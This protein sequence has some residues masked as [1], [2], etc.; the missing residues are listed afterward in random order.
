MLN[1]PRLNKRPSL[2]DL[3]Q[4]KNIS[5]ISSFSNSSSLFEDDVEPRTV[6]LPRS[7]PITPQRE[8]VSESPPPPIALNEDRDEKH[9]GSPAANMGPVSSSK[10]QHWLCAGS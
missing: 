8:D 6:P 1:R 2:L 10:M 9:K 4:K 7:P 3:I 5:Y